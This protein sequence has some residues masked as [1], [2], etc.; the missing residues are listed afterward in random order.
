M[1]DALMSEVFEMKD[2]I[3]LHLIQKVNSLVNVLSAVDDKKTP[4]MTVCQEFV[5]KDIC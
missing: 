5:V 3:F 1:V 2:E 4:T